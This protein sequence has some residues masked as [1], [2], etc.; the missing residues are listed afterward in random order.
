MWFRVSAGVLAIALAVC[1]AVPYATVLA[2]QSVVLY[3]D[4]N[5]KFI[6][7]DKWLGQDFGF[8][9]VDRREQ[10]R[11]IKGN[12]LR[13]ASRL[14]GD[15][16]TA[17]GSRNGG[18]RVRF[19][20]PELVTTIRAEL[21]ATEVDLLGCSAQAPAS[22]RATV[23]GFF[24]NDGSSTGPNDR[25]GE[26]SAGISIGSSS[27]VAD[28][29][30]VLTV[31]A[32]AFH[33]S[34]AQCSSA[35][36][37]GGALLGSVLL[38]EKTSVALAWDQTASQFV[39]QFGN[40]LPVSIGYSFATVNPPAVD[41]KIIDVSN[42]VRNCGSGVRSLAYMELFVDNVSVNPVP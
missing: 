25:T 32:F 34:N 19:S 4:F 6:N 8:T 17:V 37:L 15:P 23:Q 27:A 30:G 41:S 28:P 7:P 33:C 16:L 13:L 10:V 22:A 20:H 12:A 40:Q 39:F 9:E 5:G 14:Y 24:F 38:K 31:T 1:V 18:S 11:E 35:T 3:D 26:V 2:Q 42:S 21:R 36:S 29:P